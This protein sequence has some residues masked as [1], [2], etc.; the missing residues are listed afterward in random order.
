MKILVV[1]GASGGHIFPALGF[2]EAFKECRPEAE[3]LLVLPRIGIRARL[4]D[5]GVRV[6]YVSVASINV[7]FDL[8]NIGR[9]AGFLK[10][11]FESMRILRSFKPDLVAGFG[12]V[13]SVPMVLCASFLRVKTIIHE[14]NV[15]PG[16]ANRF[17]SKFAG[18]IAVSFEGTKEY[19]KGAQGKVV[20]TGNPVRR[21]LA[22]CGRNEALDFFSFGREGVTVLVMGGSQGSRSIN[23]G[24]MRALS[25]IAPR[26]GLRVIHIAGAGDHDSLSRFYSRAE[27]PHRLFEFLKPMRYAYSA[28]DLVVSRAGATTIA[29]LLVFKVP[30]ILI[31]YPFA[32]GHQMANAR[33]LEEA[34]AAMVIEDKALDTPALE[35]ALSRFLGDAAMRERMRAGY[36]NV[37]GPRPGKCLVDAA[38]SLIEK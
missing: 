19:F 16:S 25:A 15:Y 9:V 18:R 4:G 6:A 17:L 26:G 28:S 23:A 35:V 2:L 31:P 10:G 34:G 21:E 30:A 7:R 33:V 11:F 27:I 1:T 29:E 5:P 8:K 32:R 38:L 22:P 3:A 24:F 37:S 12:S 14:Q 13:V 20:V 36:E